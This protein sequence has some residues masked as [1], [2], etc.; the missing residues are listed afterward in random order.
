M[1]DL[2][3]TV[4]RCGFFLDVFGLTFPDYL[5]CDIFTESTDP[6]VCIGHQ[7][8]IEA[9][10]R[11]ARPGKNIYFFFLSISC[12]NGFCSFD[13]KTGLIFVYI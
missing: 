7:E 6:N 11:A 4:R 5:Q 9:E 13:K 8:V 2:S 10:K 1:F 12:L 3:E